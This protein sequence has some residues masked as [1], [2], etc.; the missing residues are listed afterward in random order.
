MYNKLFSAVS[1]R[2]Y[3]RE[4]KHRN[5]AIL[6]KL[7]TVSFTMADPQ[8]PANAVQEAQAVLQNPAPDEVQALVAPAQAPAQQ[9]Q[10]PAQ[11]NEVSL[12]VCETLFFLSFA[13]CFVLVLELFVLFRFDA[14]VLF[15]AHP[16]F[17]FTTFLVG[18]GDHASCNLF[19]FT[20]PCC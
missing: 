11:A 6:S 7:R 9:A 20:L 10:A 18:F 19:V 4:S 13:T 17:T 5:D 14:S 15:C 16:A 2:T 8:V 1:P 12:E 3:K